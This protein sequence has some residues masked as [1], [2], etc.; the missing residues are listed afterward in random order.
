M[1]KSFYVP[2][3]HEPSVKPSVVSQVLLTECDGC[4]KFHSDIHAILREKSLSD[5]I[6]PESL[7]QIVDDMVRPRPD[8]S[9]EGLS[10]DQLFDTI[11]DR[12]CTDFNDWHQIT[13]Y[14]S[15]NREEVLKRLSDFKA[16]QKRLDDLNEKIFGK[17]EVSQ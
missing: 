1:A 16:K 14:L 11:F 15:E 4:K 13:K 12:R 6:S 5:V 10:D 3:V 9:S 8:S 7:R 2:Y 17:K